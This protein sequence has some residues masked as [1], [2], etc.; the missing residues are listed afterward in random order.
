MNK[1]GFG[2]SWKNGRFEWPFKWENH[3]S[4]MGIYGDSNRTLRGTIWNLMRQWESHGN[5]IP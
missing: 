1:A 4:F 5:F 2:A 3:R